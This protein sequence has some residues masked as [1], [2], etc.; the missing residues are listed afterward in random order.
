MTTIRS[1][2]VYC[3]SSPG[4]HPAFVEAGEQLGAALAQAGVMLVYG[5]G[6]HGVMGAV[7]RGAQS[8]GGRIAAIIPDFL[9]NREANLAVKD[10]FEDLT[11]T[12][13]MHERKQKMFER[14]DA[15]VALPGGIGT[16]EEI[17]EVMTWAQIGR[18]AKPMAFANINGFWSPFL[19]FIETLRE[20]GFIHSG[21][22]V[23]PLVLE[24]I[25][26]ILPG[27]NAAARGAPRA[28]T[29]SENN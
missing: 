19:D 14:S 20:T 7:A 26:A 22:L 21:N 28:E 23:R 25:D 18:H 12:T 8:N 6:L 17:V 4:N 10:I 24:R 29:V 16:I 1:V 15:F 9:V 5:G 27:L 13:T 3:G 2:C 11:I